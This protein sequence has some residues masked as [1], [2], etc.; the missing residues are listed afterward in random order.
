[1]HFRKSQIYMVWLQIKKMDF[2]LALL[3]SFFREQ[4]LKQDLSNGLW[5]TYSH[6]LIS[7]YSSGRLF[8]SWKNS[9]LVNLVYVESTL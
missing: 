8:P 4:R 7:A 9:I 1:M 5:S 3:K 6:I 2:V